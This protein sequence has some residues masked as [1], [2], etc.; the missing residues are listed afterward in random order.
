MVSGKYEIRSVEGASN[1]YNMF[2]DIDTSEKRITG[3]TDC[4]TFSG[5]Y[6]IN[7]NEVTFL[8]FISTKMYCEEHVMKVETSIFKA[9]SN[10]KKFTFDNNMITL[11]NEDGTVSLKAYKVIKEDK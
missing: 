6:T 4:N 3:K 11:I 2:F 5:N 7:E 1:L 9:F 10:T 8:P